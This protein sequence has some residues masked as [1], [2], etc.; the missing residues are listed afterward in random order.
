MGYFPPEAGSYLINISEIIVGIC[1]LPFEKQDVV[2]ND[3]RSS[4]VH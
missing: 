2:L 1:F 3:K 4:C